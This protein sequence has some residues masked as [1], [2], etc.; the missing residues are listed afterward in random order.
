M[1]KQDGISRRE[2]IT[3]TSAAG[4]GAALGAGLVAGT[5]SDAFAAP[6]QSK[7]RVP[8]KTL[9]KTGQKVPILLFGG[10]VDL[11]PKFDPK[12]AEAYRYGV[13]YFDAAKV[14]G[15]GTCEPR[16]GN[17]LERSG[18]RKKVWITTKSPEHEA[19]PFARDVDNSLKDLKTKYIDLYFMHSIGPDKY[20]RGDLGKQMAKKAEQLKKQGK[21]RY[22]GFSCHKSN[23]AELLELAATLPWIDVVM[24]K[25]NFRD[26]GDKK[27]NKAIDAAH[28]ANI[29]LIAMKTQGAAVSFQEKWKPHKASG[30]TKGQAVLKAVWDDERIAAAVSHMDSLSLVRENVAAAL[31]KKK[32]TAADRESLQRYA[33]DTRQ[34]HCQWCDHHCNP[35]VDAPVQIGDTL[36]FL[37]YHDVYGEKD[38]ARRLFSELPAEARKLDGVDFSG[39]NRACPNG[40]NVA[41]HMK[42]AKDVLA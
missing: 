24:F 4:A 9:G 37:M 39:A 15:G 35:A 1:K 3:K 10:A 14:Y 41:Y 27:L 40:V 38:K 29:G 28:K 11:D 25:Y 7:F 5:A 42:R 34:H 30:F 19:E 26:Y 17:F 22:F 23:V 13:D 21:I 18:L 20:L 32:L 12:L 8:R 2:L 36:R 33:Q 6:K 31:N 16:V